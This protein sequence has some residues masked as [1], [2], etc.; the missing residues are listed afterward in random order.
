MASPTSETTPTSWPRNTV[1]EFSTSFPL[2]TPYK[3]NEDE[4]EWEYEYSQT[5]TEVRSCLPLA[6]DAM[7][8]DANS[9]VTDILRDHG[10]VALGHVRQS[11]G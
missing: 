5:E 10:P 1:P 11:Q 9:I 8:R 4:D 2:A 3:A 6:A 7:P